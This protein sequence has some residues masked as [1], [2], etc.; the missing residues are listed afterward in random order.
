MDKELKDIIDKYIIDFNE[1]N[2]NFLDEIVE[3]SIPVIWFGDMN[4][5]S[6]AKND[7]KIMKIVT[8]A[9]N[10]SNKEFRNNK[11][12]PVDPPRFAKIDLTNY[13][14]LSENEK[15]K[16]INELANTYNRYFSTNP[17]NWFEHF[18]KILRYIGAGYDDENSDF[19][20][21][22]IDYYSAIATKKKWANI[23]RKSEIQNIDLFKALFEYLDPDIILFSSNSD[24]FNDLK[25]YLGNV[26]FEKEYYKMNQQ[27]CETSGNLKQRTN[28]LGINKNEEKNHNDA[29]IR[30][31]KM[32]ENKKLVWGKCNVNPFNAF[33]DKEKEDIMKAEF[34][35]TV[36]DTDK[37]YLKG[38]R[39]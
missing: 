20:V 28:Q 14:K 30:I 35:H 8:I 24:A 39:E 11:N 3:N 13:N 18:N 17:Y 6:N 15:D 33:T 31:Y 38:T 27:D 32:S 2:E 22:H 19:V 25:M 4:K 16:Q 10:P 5:Y 21:V 34:C 12:D 36:L 29:Y 23:K 26:K 9:N 7:R 1:K 37:K